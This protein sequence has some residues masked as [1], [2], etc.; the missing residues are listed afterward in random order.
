MDPLILAAFGDPPDN[1]D[2]AESRTRA[3]NAAVIILI[4]IASVAVALRL[5][6]RKFQSVGLKADDY[7]ILV[8]LVCQMVSVQT[9]GVA[10]CV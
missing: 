4:L 5:M 9:S 6:A 3:D 2:L 7:I 10:Y 1:L 8:S